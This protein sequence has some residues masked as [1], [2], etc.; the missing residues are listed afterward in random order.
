MARVSN[1]GTN[2]PL[3]PS[4]KQGPAVPH[5]AR[6]RT[7]CCRERSAGGSGG[8]CGRHSLAKPACRGAGGVVNHERFGRPPPG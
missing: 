4:K 5:P 7:P 2:P 6:G 8:Q 1:M 3:E